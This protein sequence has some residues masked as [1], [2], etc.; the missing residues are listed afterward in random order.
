MIIQHLILSHLHLMRPPSHFSQELHPCSPAL[1]GWKDFESFLAEPFQVS[2]STSL[3]ITLSS[4]LSLSLSSSM[5]TSTMLLSTSRMW[6]GGAELTRDL[7]LA[8]GR[9]DAA[10]YQLTR[11]S[12]CCIFVAKKLKIWREFCFQKSQHTRSVAEEL[13][14][15]LPA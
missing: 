7:W 9:K 3:S 2:I 8:N 11:V 5:S 13:L 1:G 4:S 10:T 15:D 12:K 14:M 6:S